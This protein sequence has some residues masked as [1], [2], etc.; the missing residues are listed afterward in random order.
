MGRTPS[1]PPMPVVM[2]PVAEYHIFVTLLDFIKHSHCKVQKNKSSKHLDCVLAI[3]NLTWHIG[4]GITHKLSCSCCWAKIH[5]QTNH[6]V[7]YQNL[8][9]F[10]WSVFGVVGEAMPNWFGVWDGLSGSETKWL[11]SPKKTDHAQCWPLDQFIDHVAQPS[12]QDHIAPDLTRGTLQS[13]YPPPS[14]I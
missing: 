6:T 2:P 1:P 14:T 11:R 9:I 8:R 5:C 4:C 12:Y 10:Q 7:P 13:S 3:V